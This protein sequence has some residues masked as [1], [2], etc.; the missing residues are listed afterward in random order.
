MTPEMNASIRASLKAIV[1]LV[2]DRTM[3]QAFL[4]EAR[5]CR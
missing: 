4:K 1:F 2:R 5:I 3:E